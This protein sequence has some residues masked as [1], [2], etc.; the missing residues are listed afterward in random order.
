MKKPSA[1][2]QQVQ[3]VEILAAAERTRQACNKLTDEERRNLRQRALAIIYGHD[4]KISA[5]SH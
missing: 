1:K 2:E 4:A 3:R 5:R